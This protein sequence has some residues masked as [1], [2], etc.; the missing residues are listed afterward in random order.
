MNADWLKMLV[1]PEDNSFSVE[2]LIGF[3]AGHKPQ[4]IRVWQFEGKSKAG[5][6]AYAYAAVFERDW[7]D[8]LC[9]VASGGAIVGNS[10]YRGT[11]YVTY[12]LMEAFLQQHRIESDSEEWNDPQRLPSVAEIQEIVVRT[13]PSAI[14]HREIV[15]SSDI[16]N[17][18]RDTVTARIKAE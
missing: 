6:T 13:V 12:R 4:L 2:A 18:L 16:L 9:I 8:Y 15:A 1:L 17:P 10:E 3:I 5:H 7:G 14:V 11:G